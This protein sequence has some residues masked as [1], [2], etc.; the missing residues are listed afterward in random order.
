MSGAITSAGAVLVKCRCSAVAVTAAARRRRK[1][2][3]ERQGLTQSPNTR[4][5]DQPGMADGAG[6][7]TSANSV[8]P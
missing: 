8:A 5:G 2:S 1:S 7:A 3:S 4:T 6:G